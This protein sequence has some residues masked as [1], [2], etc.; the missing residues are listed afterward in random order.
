MKISKADFE[1]M[2]AKYSQEVKKGNPGKSKKGNVIDQTDWIFF[3]KADLEAALANSDP[4]IGGIKF[5]LT[6]YTES[7]AKKYHPENP[8]AYEGK[9]ALVYT[10]S[11][12]PST[13]KSTE[14]GGTTYYNRGVTCPPW[15]E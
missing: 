14:D 2:K 15:C 10:G 12:D 4:Q 9:I 1:S 3:S 11:N 8:D 5:Y 6:E 7:I 13:S